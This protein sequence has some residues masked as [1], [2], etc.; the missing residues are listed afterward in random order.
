MMQVHDRA[1][2]AVC[3][4][5]CFKETTAKLRR[6][7]LMESVPLSDIARSFLEY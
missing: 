5:S 1:S 2:L 6:K 3:V 7:L 4:L